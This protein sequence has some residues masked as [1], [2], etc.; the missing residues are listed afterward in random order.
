MS[1][2]AR[3][4]DLLEA[5]WPSIA[6]VEQ[7]APAGDWSVWLYLGG[8]GAGKT[9]SGAETI[10]EWI[11]SGQC[12]RIG[13]ISPT[14]ADA[15]DVLTEGPSGILSIW[16]QSS[17]PVYEP[18]KRRITFQNGAIATLFSSEEPD[19]LRGPQ[20]DAA[21]CDELAAWRNAQA[22]W[23]NLMLG[24]RLGRRP[25][26][27]V[28]TTP[29]PIALLKAILKREGQDVV[30]TRGKTSDNAANL[31]PTFLTEI[32]GRYRGTRLERQEL[33]AELLEDTPGALWSLAL[34]EEGR[35]SKAEL[36]EMRRIVISVDPAVTAHEGSNESG[37]VA[38]GLG[39]NGH[40][41]L[42]EDASGRYSP[43]EW[44]HKAVALFHKWKADRIVAE[45]NQGGELV[46]Q[47]IMTVFAN[48]PI[49]LVH[50]SH[51]KIARAEPV[52]ALAE[53]FR[54]HHIGVFPELEDQLCSYAPGSSGSPDR[55][56]AF[57]WAMHELM[58]GVQAPLAYLRPEDILIPI[59][60]G[61]FEAQLAGS[62]KNPALSD[63]RNRGG[64]P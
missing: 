30:V 18:S 60:P 59:L 11:E 62:V 3:I 5:D 47:T 24:L 40:G 28:T 27:I 20:F 35:R 45:A 36:P 52:A 14:S 39:E 50:A 6:R 64:F 10:R 58:L 17:R 49:K 34:I 22:T 57:V 13:L 37:V 41:Y 54:L 7:I 46:R 2:F 23:D 26:C 21:W 33:F 8:R 43:S 63:Y 51:G 32:A 55:L 61:G 9:R 48:A 44:A 29:R 25:R 53:Q 38:C 56:D 42:L 1:S 4:A 19:R 16:P 31:A 15:R 12:R